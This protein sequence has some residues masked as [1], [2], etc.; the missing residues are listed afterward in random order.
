MNG[1]DCRTTAD[2]TLPRNRSWSRSAGSASSWAMF[3]CR[4]RTGLHNPSAVRAFLALGAGY[5]ALDF[6]FWRMG[7]VFLKR[8]PLFVSFME[9][10]F[11]ALLCYHDTGLAQPV[12]LVLPAL[13]D[14]L[15]DPLPAGGGLVDSG[16]PFDQPAEPG[17][18]AGLQ[19][20]DRLGLAA[21]AGDHGLGDLGQLVA[22]G[23]AQGGRRPVAGL[24]LRAGA[25]SGQSWRSGSPS[26][27][28]RCGPRRP[29]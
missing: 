19:H 20:A 10:I 1:S 3:W 11:I 4:R 17:L 5:A 22:G 24:E 15:R 16:I 23:S 21:D 9:S 18:V 28:T 8:W 6:A 26:E 27:P 12:S 7:E 25:T 2:G 14:L 13:L 29:G